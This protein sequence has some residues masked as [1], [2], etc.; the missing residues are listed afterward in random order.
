MTTFQ[1]I[2]L[3]SLDPVGEDRRDEPKLRY[4]D[5]LKAAQALKSQ[6]RHFAL[7]RRDAHR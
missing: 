1:I 3:S 4:P 6:A 7:L 2:A 5:A